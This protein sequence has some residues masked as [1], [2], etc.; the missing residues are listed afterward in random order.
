LAA[1]SGTGDAVLSTDSE[2]SDSSAF[3]D[4]SFSKHDSRARAAAFAASLAVN[5]DCEAFLG[6][7]WCEEFVHLVDLLIADDAKEHTFRL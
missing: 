6:G 4:H 7:R 1:A 3:R 5:D 2:Q